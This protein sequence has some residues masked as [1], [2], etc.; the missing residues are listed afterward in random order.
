MDAELRQL[1]QDCELPD[2]VITRMR[3][4][5]EIKCIRHLAHWCSHVGQVERLLFQLLPMRPTRVVLANLRAAWEAASHRESDQALQ[6][7]E[8]GSVAQI[9]DNR[10]G[11]LQD[12]WRAQ[13]IIDLPETW[14]APDE[15]VDAYLHALEC[16]SITEQPV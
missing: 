2:D 13:P 12:A 6:T 1:L 10:H 16:R 3:D 8:I 15:C 7:Q 5:C 14:Q 4:Q 9:D 11:Q